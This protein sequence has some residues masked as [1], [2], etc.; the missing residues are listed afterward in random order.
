MDEFLKLKSNVKVTNKK[1]N[2]QQ[3]DSCGSKTK[4]PKINLFVQT[5][6]V[7]QQQQQQPKQA[8]PQ[9]Q[10]S[11]MPLLNTPNKSGIQIQDIKIIPSTSM[12]NSN[13]ITASSIQSM[14][15][16]PK[17]QYMMPIVLNKDGTIGTKPNTDTQQLI[18]QA[19]QAAGNQ[20]L[21]VNNANTP[22]AYLQMKVNHSKSKS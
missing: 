12:Q 22:V 10:K 21:T 20:N 19:L 3:K 1:E 9:I 2:Q 11:V 13:I 17:K 15:T 8:T 4:K 16:T 18:T 6:P 7:K 14:Q 5:T